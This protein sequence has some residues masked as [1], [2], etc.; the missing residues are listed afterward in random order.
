MIK[1]LNQTSHILNGPHI[2]LIIGV[3]LLFSVFSEI[4]GEIVDVL[5]SA[6]I[7]IHHG[8]VAFGLIHVL[9]ALAALTESLVLILE[10]PKG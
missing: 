3:F 1:F 8:I 2:N 4:E 6:D 5:V 9:S 10:R 7:G